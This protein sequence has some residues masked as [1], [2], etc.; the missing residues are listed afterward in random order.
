[1]YL[2]WPFEKLQGILETGMDHCCSPL[3]PLH[4]LAGILTGDEVSVHC[5]TEGIRFSYHFMLS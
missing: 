3:L 4:I 1:M 2:I 5:G